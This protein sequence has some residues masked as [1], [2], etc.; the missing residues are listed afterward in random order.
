MDTTLTIKRTLVWG[1]SMVT[2]IIISLAIV[3]VLL[4]SDLDTYTMK[5]FILTFIPIGIIF[6]IWGDLLLGTKILPE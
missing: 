2:G 6:V 3:Y 1:V 4:D 5:Y